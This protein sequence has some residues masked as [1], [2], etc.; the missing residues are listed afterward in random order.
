M[1]T[2]KALRSLRRKNEVFPF[3]SL[4][5]C[6]QIEIICLQMAF[7]KLTNMSWVACQK[8]LPRN[9][10]IFSGFD[11]LNLTVKLI[12]FLFNVKNKKNRHLNL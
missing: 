11:K 5:L 8:G 1:L 12:N 10:S 2:T 6:G 3:C 9:L 4:C 7:N